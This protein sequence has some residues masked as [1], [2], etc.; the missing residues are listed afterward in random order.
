MNVFVLSKIVSLMLQSGDKRSQPH[1]MRWRKTAVNV[2]RSSCALYSRGIQVVIRGAPGRFVD[3]VT[4]V[5]NSHRRTRLP[6]RLV[7]AG[8]REEYTIRVLHCINRRNRTN[9]PIIYYINI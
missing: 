7:P 4:F 8:C 5:Q 2:F 3:D 6:T 9:V 1:P